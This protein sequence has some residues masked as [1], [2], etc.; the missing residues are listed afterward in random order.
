MLIFQTKPHYQKLEGRFKFKYS[1]IMKKYYIT[2]IL[3]LIIDLTFGQCAMCRA[4]LEN[5]AVNQ[6]FF[7]GINAGILYLMLIP[8]LAMGLIAYAWYRNSRKTT[9][10]RQKILDVVA[11]VK[12]K[13]R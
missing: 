7:A 6:G 1:K 4:T 3:V 5:Q 13:T 8:Y 9:R 12:Q 10:E 2:V 11:R